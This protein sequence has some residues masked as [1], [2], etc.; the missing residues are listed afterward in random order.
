MGISIALGEV[1]IGLGTLLGLWGRV[2]AAAGALLSFMLFL[3]VSFHSSPYFTGADIVFFFA[4]TSLIASGS[5][6]RFSIDGVIARRAAREGAQPGPELVAMPFTQVQH[7]CGHYQKGRC[8]AQNGAP[9][10]PAGCPVLEGPRASLVSRGSTDRVDRR[11]L[12]LGATS[13]GFLAVAGALV[14]GVAAAMGRLLH[15]SHQSST[16]TITSTPTTAGGNNSSLGTLLGAASQVP[17]GQAATFTVPST[18]DPG[19][20]ICTSAGN[21][22]AYDTICPHAGCTVGFSPSSNLMVCPCHGSQF[23]V[24]NGN[25]ISGPAPSGLL[26]V[27]VVEGHD[28]NLYVS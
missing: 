4:W 11:M 22:V 21:F 13:V 7:L 12:M 5:G 9:C 3:T 15:P 26:A 19:I 14:S 24:S 16:K 25:V 2:A 18:G 20:V 27:K 23:L 1:A 6:A 8:R 10:A 28:G 17:V